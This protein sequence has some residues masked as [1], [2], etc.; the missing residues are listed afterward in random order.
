MNSIIVTNLAYMINF[1][2]IMK[3]IKNVILIKKICIFICFHHDEKFDWCDFLATVSWI[4]SIIY[5]Y[6]RWRISSRKYIIKMKNFINVYNFIKHTNCI[7]IIRFKKESRWVI[8]F[9]WMIWLIW[10]ISSVIISS[11]QMACNKT[12]QYISLNIFL[13]LKEKRVM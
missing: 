1:I 9:R 2:K 12:I 11:L 5:I 13:N 6:S 10:W 3:V 8:S 7:E 4:L